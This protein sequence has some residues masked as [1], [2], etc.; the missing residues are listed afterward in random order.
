MSASSE[1]RVAIVLGVIAVAAIPAGVAVAAY[2][3]RVT[4]LQA[5]YVAV[6]VSFVVALCALSASRRARARLE[7][8]VQRVG[9]GSVR[10]G[11]FLALAGLWCA[12]TGALALG[13]YGLLHVTS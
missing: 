4:L 6:P 7:R 1:G 10:A 11:R 5:V 8:T 2:A 3:T 13:F 12:L 9:Q